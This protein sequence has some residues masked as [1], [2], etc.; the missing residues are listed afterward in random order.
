MKYIIE[1]MED[2]FSEWVIL[3]YGQIARDLAK[4]GQELWL[5]SIK[6]GLEIPAALRGI[7]NLKWTR[8]DVK[9]YLP[10]DTIAERVCLLDPAADQELVPSDSEKFDYF[11]FGGI[12][13]DHP[14]RD[15]TGELRQLG[16]VGRNLDKVQMTTDTAVRVTSKV[17]TGGKK[18]Q[19]INY[20]DFP[21]LR[22]SKYEST[23]MPFR[24]VTNE[25]GEPILPEGMFELIQKDSDK[26]LEDL[27]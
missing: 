7:A 20:V 2:G 10:P 23:E 14:P 18:L 9:S 3:E 16:Y 17:L 1:H 8:E 24:Y 27:L 21:E 25:K 12:L 19:E 5:T 26:S 4:L 6:E 15:R 11:L 22:F 13:G